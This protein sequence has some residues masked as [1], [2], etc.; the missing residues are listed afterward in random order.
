[1]NQY[2]LLTYISLF[3]TVLPICAGISNIMRMDR[4]MKVLISYLIFIFVAN[5]IL[6]WFIRGRVLM[7]GLTHVYYILEYVFI[8]TILYKW[9]ESNSTKRFIKTLILVYILFWIIAKF[10]FEPLSGLYSITATT[11]QVLLTLCAGYT[12]FIVIGNREQPL[13]NNYR[14]WVLLSFVIYYTGTLLSIAL[15]GI[16]IHYAIGIFIL[17]ASIDWTMKILFSILIFIG[18]LCPQTRIK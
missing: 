9:Q 3:S 10:T 6:M 2:P 4:G 8:M 15:R 18:F 16:L 13:M 1:M 12:L 17:V 14:F 11:S 5:I 7:I